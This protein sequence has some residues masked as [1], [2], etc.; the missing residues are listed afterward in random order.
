MVF[1]FVCHAAEFAR[2]C[3]ANTHEARV[4]T[5]HHRCTDVDPP[6]SSVCPITFLQFPGAWKEVESEE[7]GMNYYHNVETKEST[8]DKIGRASC[9]ERV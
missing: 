2:L 8:W 7:H 3:K 5:L 6:P 4:D 1:F 9:R